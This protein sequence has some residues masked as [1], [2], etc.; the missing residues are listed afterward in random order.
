MSTLE[1]P[2]WTILAQR[3]RERTA[4]P[5]LVGNVMFH[6]I[7][8]TAAQV[9]MSKSWLR[10]LVAHT[11]GLD[12]VLETRT[13]IR[14]IRKPRHR[15]DQNASYYFDVATVRAYRYSSLGRGRR[16]AR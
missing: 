6:G 16:R 11:P 8:D 15:G 3:A 12:E 4:A 5:I 7:E 2:H 1:F 14:F 9:G 10:T 13:G